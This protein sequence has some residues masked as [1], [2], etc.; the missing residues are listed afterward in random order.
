MMPRKTAVLRQRCMAADRRPA[1]AVQHGEK[2][3]LGG[4]RDAV[5][6]SAMTTSAAGRASPRA[7]LERDHALPDRR[8]KFV[9]P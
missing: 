1:G 7:R 8:Q 9:H 2:G 6:T 3:A 5:S 4:E